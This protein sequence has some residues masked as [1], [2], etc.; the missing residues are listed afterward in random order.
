M[1]F[2]G[3]SDVGKKRQI[4]EDRYR[5]SNDRQFCILA[6]GMGGRSFGE[7]ASTMAVD[8]LSRHIEDELPL[9]LR[10]LDRSEQAAMLVTYLDEW[11]R[12][13]NAAIHRKGQ[14]DE[15]YLEMGTTLV[16]LCALDRQIVLAHIGDSRCYRFQDSVLTQITEDHSFV[17]TQVK[18]GVLTEEEAKESRQRNIITRA[19]GTAAK[20]KPDIRIHATIP[21]QRYLLSTDGLHDVVDHDTITRIMQRQLSLEETGRELV[22]AANGDGGRDNITVLLA[23]CE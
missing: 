14:E 21:G 12:D 15:K 13:V 22:N 16:C 6:D 1:T 20:V 4:N 19:V 7:V 8:M 18:S 23:E 5:V 17:N 11:I 2:F 10:R 3:I 9:S